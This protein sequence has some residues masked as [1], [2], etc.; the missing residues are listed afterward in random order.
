MR[1]LLAALIHR[2]WSGWMQYLFTKCTFNDDGTATIPSWA[3]MRWRR[4]INTAYWDLTEAERDSDR[5]EADKII[6]LLRGRLK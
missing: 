1:E 4:Q 2:I 3:V 5:A 6:A